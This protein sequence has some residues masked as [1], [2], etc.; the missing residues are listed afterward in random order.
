MAALIVEAKF[1]EWGKDDSLRDMLEDISA[2]ILAIDSAPADAPKV[3]E[4]NSDPIRAE[5]LYHMNAGELAALDRALMKSV[6]IVPDPLRAELLEALK[7][8]ERSLVTAIRSAMID[9]DFDAEEKS[10]IVD[11][12]PVIVAMRAAINR[13]EAAT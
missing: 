6:T 1:K 5:P 8:G 11:A 7:K 10:G 9:S 3:R 13:A 4:P 12:N 2:D